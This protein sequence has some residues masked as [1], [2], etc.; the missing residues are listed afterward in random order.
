[1]LSQVIRVIPARVDNRRTVLVIED[2]ELV[3][4]A[5]GRANPIFYIR[6]TIAVRIKG[7]IHAACASRGRAAADNAVICAEQSYAVHIR[8]HALALIAILCK[9][10]WVAEIILLPGTVWF[11]P[12][13]AIVL[14][15]AG[16]AVV[17]FIYASHLAALSIAVR[18]QARIYLRSRADEP[19][20]ATGSANL[21]ANHF[22]RLLFHVYVRDADSAWI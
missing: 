13:V 22:C 9:I 17:I 3:P 4:V 14:A 8:L 1:M 7:G 16:S 5:P 19:G 11:T 6:V 12:L 10:G 18:K 2:A 20:R 21:S 15:V